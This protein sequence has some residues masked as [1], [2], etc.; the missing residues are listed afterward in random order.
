MK[1]YHREVQLLLRLLLLNVRT[2]GTGTSSIPWLP[3]PAPLV[4]ALDSVPYLTVLD[5][6]E[7]LSGRSRAVVSPAIPS[8]V[9]A[10]VVLV[11]VS[12]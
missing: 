2:L 8:V 10:V 1:T 11:V 7:R 5:D 9:V 12:G 6:D 4:P 3:L